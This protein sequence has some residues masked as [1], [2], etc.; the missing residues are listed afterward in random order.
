MYEID[1]PNLR[2]VLDHGF[3]YLVDT[4][5]TDQAICQSARI[6]YGQGTKSINEDRGLIR[7]LFRNRHTSPIESCEVKYHLRLPI[8]VMRQLV[9]HRTASLN[10]YSARYSVLSDDFYVPD[11]GAIQPQSDANKQ[12]R[13]GAISTASAV[14]VQWVMRTIGENCHDVYTLL[15]GG[16]KPLDADAQGTSLDVLLGA[17]FPGISR[18]IARAIL[19]V[20]AYTECYWKQDLHNLFHLLKLR[21]DR[22]A[23]HE[24]RVYADA[25][26]ELIKPVFPLACEAWEDY[27]RD[28]VNLS[29]ME[30]ALLA[31]ALSNKEG[32]GGLMEDFGYDDAQI[33]SHYGLTKRELTEF[34]ERMKLG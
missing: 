18:E 1:D 9:R 33:C 16:N 17:E 11:V 10:E 30:A 7:Y 2:P 8:F 28:A 12:G 26:Y 15:L 22:H 23:Q 13:S 34:K 21:C 32:F 6:S 3:V 24:I 31:D 19:P 4:M 20:S 5:G 14:A 27:A 25:M 29:R